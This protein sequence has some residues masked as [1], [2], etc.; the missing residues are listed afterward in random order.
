MPPEEYRILPEEKSNEASL[1][2]VFFMLLLP[3]AKA[4][5]DSVRYEPLFAD[6][7]DGGPYRVV[8]VNK[9]EDASA[10]QQRRREKERIVD[11]KKKSLRSFIDE[12]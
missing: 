12:S 7:K 2:S 1:E 11:K 5:D 6:R 3:W 8:K 4:L 9:E 10:E